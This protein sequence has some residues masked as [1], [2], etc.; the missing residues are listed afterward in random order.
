MNLITVEELV[1]IKDDS[2]LLLIDVRENDE[3]SLTPM[4]GMPYVHIPMNDIPNRLDRID[5]NKN[6]IIF[7][8]SGKRSGKVCEYLTSN[9][10]QN[11]S[12]LVGGILA[13]SK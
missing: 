5:E 4:A 1:N 11:V 9:G 12:N 2:N 3:V 10:Y 8:R 7:C 13:W 6:I